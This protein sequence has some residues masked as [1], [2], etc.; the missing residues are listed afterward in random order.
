MVHLSPRHIRGRR[1]EASVLLLALACGAIACGPPAVTEHAPAPAR[2]TATG[3]IDPGAVPDDTIK[4]VLERELGN[5][6]RLSTEHVGVTVDNGIV[7]LQ[8]TLESRLTKERA[9]AMAHVVR[10]VR[11]VVDRIDVADHP[12]EDHELEVVVARVLSSD[13]VTR[14]QRITPRAHNGTVALSGEVDSFATR[15]VA[16]DDVLGIP[17]VV[18]VDDNLAIFPRRRSDTYLADIVTRFLDDDPWLDDDRVSASADKE[19][20]ALTGFVGSEEEL[21]RAEHD[22]QMAGPRGGVDLTRLRIDHWT[23]D[24]TL[25]AR[26]PVALGDR[27][28]GQA[29][30]DAYVIDAR[31][32]PFAP[33]IDVHAHVVILTGVSP[34]PEAKAAAVEDAA[35]TSGV[36]DVRDDMKL[37]PNVVHRTDPQ[38]RADVV[39][40]I[41]DDARLRRLHFAVDV[42]D[43]TVYLR[44]AVPTEADR[45]H[46]IVLATS[47]PGARQVE[48]SLQLLPEG[49]ANIQPQPQ[50]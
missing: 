34:N 7:T 27:Q 6:R 1:T 21:V 12:R 13:P 11:A 4:T 36:V 16:R 43:G 2:Y 33:S 35:N 44:G 20:V 48:D 38:I 25:R 47:A 5:D 26:P 30:L 15:Q 40:A 32:H 17:G 49:V 46:A 41:L 19:R 29:L 14:G 18:N 10:G 24:G 31:V 28:I 8:G 3:T 9:V 42:V 39:T 23:D 22:A 37:L 45:L 50:P